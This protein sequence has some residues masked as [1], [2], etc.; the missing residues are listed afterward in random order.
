[1]DVNK[2]IKSSNLFI[3]YFTSIPTHFVVIVFVSGKILPANRM[4]DPRKLQY[5]KFTTCKI[6]HRIIVYITLATGTYNNRT[7]FMSFS[8]AQL[9]KTSTHSTSSRL[10]SKVLIVKSLLG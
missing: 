3:F 9:Q 8:R 2:Y 5:I 7:A 6:I 1:M 4:L 10:K